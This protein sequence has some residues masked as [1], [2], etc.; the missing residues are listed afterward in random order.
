MLRYDVG[1]FYKQ[2][3]DQNASPDSLMGV[4]LYTFFLYL[5]DVEE[6]GGPT[7]FARSLP[8]LHR[9][10]FVSSDAVYAPPGLVLVCG[11]LYLAGAFLAENQ[12]LAPTANRK[13]V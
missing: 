8:D 9:F 11:S 6:A 4:R 13:A 2:H 3:H 5:S 1:Q 12:G 7:H 10:V